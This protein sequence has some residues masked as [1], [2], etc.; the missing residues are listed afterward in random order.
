M[1]IKNWLFATLKHLLVL[2]FL[3]FILTSCGGGGGGGGGGGV[4][5]VNSPPSIAGAPSPS[6]IAGENYRFTPQASDAD[7][8]KLTFSITNLPDWAIFDTETGILEGSPDRINT[9]I[10]PEITISVSDGKA[11]VSLAKFNIGVNPKTL[12]K[13]DIAT[14]GTEVATPVS[15]L[16]DPNN[17][18]FT[19]TG[20]VTIDVNGIQRKHEQADLKFE[21]DKDDNLISMSGNALIPPAVSDYFTLNGT[22]TARIGLYRG[23]EINAEP[24]FGVQLQDEF[25]YFVYYLAV[26]VEAELGDRNGGA[27]STISLSLP[28]SGEILLISDPMDTFYYYYASTFAGSKGYGES[29]KGL[30][31]FKPIEN[32]ASLDSFNGHRLEKDAMSIGIK[33]FDLF[34]IVGTRVTKQ[35]QF[36]DIDWLEPLNSAIEFKAGANGVGKLALSVFGVGF[37]E[38]NLA[39][40][41][42]TFDVGLDRQQMAMQMTV[43]PDVS[44]Q[45]DWFSIIPNTQIIGNWMVNGD[46]TFSAL[47]SG[48]YRST[49]P[50]A[51]MTGSITLNN[52]GAIF[53][54]SIPDNDMPITVR[55]SFLKPSTIY[56]IF[57]Q[58]DASAS[59]KSDINN[60]FDRLVAEKTQAYQ[61]YQQSIADYDFEVSLRGIRTSL[62]VIADKA[63]LILKALPAEVGQTAYTETYNTIK[64]KQVCVGAV[65]RGTCVGSYQPSDSRI[66]SYARTARN[67]ARDRTTTK[68]VPYVNAMNELKKRALQ[69]DAEQL[70]Q[71]LEDSLRGAYA[72]RNY[73]DNITVS[74]TVTEVDYQ[75]SYTKPVNEPILTNSQSSSILS[76]ANNVYR[77]QETSDTRIRLGD[78][79]DQ[80][81]LEEKINQAR[82]EVNAN[83]DQLP[84]FE[85]AGMT[86]TGSKMTAYIRLGGT[87]Y[88]VDFNILDPIELLLGVGDIIVDQK[89]RGK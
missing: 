36:S 68:I 82:A 89:S 48:E 49:L 71:A 34:E 6:V 28:A 54:S 26:A 64:S 20:T 39:Q 83:L 46:G 37:F 40:V 52:N 29:D 25:Y 70:R 84:T 60:A 58:R 33:I 31:P 61:D 81:P 2:F 38:F 63:I 66:G 88:P 5:P 35:S 1:I 67:Q 62:P 32:F 27:G 4:N 22:T 53:E 44:W 57:A 17:S 12:S 14:V 77:I 87:D 55:A 47:L 72:R 65:V 56:E 78:Y 19:A 8:D 23:S 59:I 85:K 18:G 10:F 69:A 21:F 80:I 76:A 42:A 74:F 75:Y 24:L 50:Q 86:V 9:G 73:T 41:S 3:A 11:T 16:Q 43:E 15:E 13:Q 7:N 51:T 30:I 79:Y 45:P